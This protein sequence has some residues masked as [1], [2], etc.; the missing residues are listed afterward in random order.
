[1]ADIEIGQSAQAVAEDTAVVL[2]VVGD[3]DLTNQ[4]T[5]CDRAARKRSSLHDESPDFCTLRTWTA[6]SAPCLGGLRLLSGDAR[7][8]PIVDV[9]THLDEQQVL[10]AAVCEELEP[11]FDLPAHQVGID[12]RL[13]DVVVAAAGERRLLVTSHRPRREG[14]NADTVAASMDTGCVD[15]FGLNRKAR[16]PLARLRH[17]APADAGLH[18]RR[19]ARFRPPPPADG[20]SSAAP[21]PARRSR[22]A[23]GE[24]AKFAGSEGT[25]AGP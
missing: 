3:D 12:N 19:L 4:G 5:R 23:R 22:A 15:V 24:R 14:D 18:G 6:V 16:A 25:G 10:M 8:A 1:F 21:H 7:V 9:G 20:M 17:H 13:G 2:V 11:A